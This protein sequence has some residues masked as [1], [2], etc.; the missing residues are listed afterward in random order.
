MKS[1]GIENVNIKMDIKQTRCEGMD[2]T[3]LAQEKNLVA[4]FYSNKP[5]N[6][7]TN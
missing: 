6:Q 7:L 4:L 2:C 3:Q 5:S 1:D